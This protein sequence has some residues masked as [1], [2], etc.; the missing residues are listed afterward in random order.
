M[1]KIF[2]LVASLLAVARGFVPAGRSARAV[3]VVTVGAVTEA[4]TKK[5][6]SPLVDRVSL[7]A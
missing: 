5:P 2:V 6:E 3:R 4:A 7:T 1:W